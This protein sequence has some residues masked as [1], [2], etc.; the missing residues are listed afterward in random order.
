VHF[1]GRIRGR[2]LVAGSYELQVTPTLGSLIGKT[3]TVKFRIR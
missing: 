1:N 3:K 2:A